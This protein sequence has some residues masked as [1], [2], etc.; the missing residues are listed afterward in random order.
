M[1]HV[2]K[3]G[4]SVI[5]GLS[6]SGREDDRAFAEDT[7][8]VSYNCQCNWTKF[9]MNTITQVIFGR[10][11]SNLRANELSKYWRY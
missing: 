1:E 4:S 10:F 9:Y 8:P 11:E 3:S 7:I 6:L 2:Q 5:E